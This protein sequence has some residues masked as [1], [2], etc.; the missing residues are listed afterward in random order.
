MTVKKLKEAVRNLSPQERILFVQYVLDTVAQDTVV[1]NS[2]DAL[3]DEWKEELNKRSASYKRGEAKT[4]TWEE[5]KVK[6]IRN[7]S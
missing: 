4:I 2:G 1:E 5:A 7:N 3:S 6:L